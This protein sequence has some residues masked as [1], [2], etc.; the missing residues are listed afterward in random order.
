MRRRVAGFLVFATLLTACSNLG[1]GEAECVAS[2]RELAPDGVSPANVM[3]VQAVPSARYTPCLNELR[4]GWDD[5]EW[6]GR[7]G[8]AGFKITR[9]FTPFL[10]ATVTET[11][12]ISD[13]TQVESGYPDIERYEAID[14]EPVEI[15]ITL[16]PA[17][18]RPLLQ[19]KMLVEDFEGLEIDD[20]PVVWTVDEEIE[21][22]VGPR[23]NLALFRNQ[24]VWIISEL[25]AE[26]GTVEMRSN[27]PGVA[28]S[29]LRAGSALDLIEDNAP[30]VFY[31]GNWYFTFDGG[32][33]TYEFDAEGT[34]AETIEND[35]NEAIGFYPAYELV[36]LARDAGLDV[37]AD[38]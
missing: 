35:A 28:G 3:S 6:F 24:Y 34:L 23:V 4:L 1:V 36:Q 2:G 32:C 27:V 13:A 15:G 8:E 5:V 18:E 11:C 21:Q 17:D 29:G 37:G 19:A 33:I 9:G 25:D 26:E 16:I 12:D 7:D 31:K 14:F 38:D 10:T 30:D 20:R 22:Q